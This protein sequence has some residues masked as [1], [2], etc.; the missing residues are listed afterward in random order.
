MPGGCVDLAFRTYAASRLFAR[1]RACGS[2]ALMTSDPRPLI[3]HVVYRFDV[4]GLENGVVNLINRLP[5]DAYRHTIISLTDV[6]DF[7][8]RV[9]RDDVQFIALNK[10]PGHAFKL[11]PRLARLFRELCPAIVHTRNMAAL[12]VVVP[13]W[14]AGAPIRIHGEHGRDVL[15][16]DGSSG[17]HQRIRRLYR[18]FVTQ[19]IALS[20]DLQRYLIDRVGVPSDA[21]CQIYNGVDARLF[22]PGSNGREPMPGC[23]FVDPGLWLVGTVGRLQAVKDQLSLVRA[24]VRALELA[25]AQRKQLRL[26]IVGDGPLYSEAKAILTRAGI[27]DL[28]WLPGELGDIPA[29]M[30]GLDCFVLPSLAEGI[31]NTILEAMASGLPVIATAVGG[32]QELV[33]AGHTGELVPPADAE[34]LAQRTLA[35][36][37]DREKARTAGRAGRAR[38]E[39]EFGLDAMVQQYR[40]LYDRLLLE[41]AGHALRIDNT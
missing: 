8:R 26:I 34:V 31:S 6:T 40:N 28:A 15:D 29:I 17:K 18:P 3:V 22:Q 25:P 9:E 5:R 23:P 4:G 14:A 21:V 19:Y 2:G 1:I 7:R 30:R 24:F 10:S 37:R 16:L 39:R 36:A 20:R 12:E 38:V 35:Y 27:A 13:A 32:N 33:D 11:Y 41:A